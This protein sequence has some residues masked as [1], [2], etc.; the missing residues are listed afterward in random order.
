MK[1]K[2]Q[3]DGLDKVTRNCNK[4]MN[5]IQSVLGTAVKKGADVIRDDA[6]G[7][8]HNIRGDL[9][10]GVIS[11]VT[12]DKNK[13]KAFA[14]AGMDKAMNNKF[15]VTTK[16]GTRYYIPSAVEYGHRA[17]GAAM[18]IEKTKRG[19][20]KKSKKQIRAKPFMRPAMK[21]NRAEV[22]RIIENYVRSEIAKGGG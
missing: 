14:A 18:N 1:I 20:R 9:E 19:K 3:V 11:T 13:S 4:V 17:P 16:T 22:V 8:I 10:R 7:R 2:L 15:V 21:T 5:D 12:W 6:R